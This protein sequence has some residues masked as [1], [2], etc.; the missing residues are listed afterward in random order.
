MELHNTVTIFLHRYDCCAEFSVAKDHLTANL[1]FTAGFAQALPFLIPQ[2]PQQ[3][4]FHCTAGWTVTEKPGRQ[5]TGII[6]YQAIARTQV[7]ENII[8]MFV[9]QFAGGSI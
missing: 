3:Q 2:I 6:H 9:F 7:I 1:H 4:N 5:N 8:K